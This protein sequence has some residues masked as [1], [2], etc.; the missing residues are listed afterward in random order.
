MPVGCLPSRILTSKQNINTPLRLMRKNLLR[1]QNL[2]QSTKSSPSM[3]NHSFYITAVG[4]WGMYTTFSHLGGCL[5][6]L[7]ERIS[8]SEYRLL[9]SVAQV[10]QDYRVG[11]K[12]EQKT[13]KIIYLHCQMIFLLPLHEQLKPLEKISSSPNAMFMNKMDPLVSVTS[14]DTFYRRTNVT[15]RY[16]V[17]WLYFILPILLLLLP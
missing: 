10:K 7:W 16:I 11:S 6:V 8:M 13:W 1:P 5:S 3:K 12:I 15:A 4:N 17:T 14:S 2:C 9:C